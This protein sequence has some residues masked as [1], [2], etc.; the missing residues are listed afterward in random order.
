MSIIA[1][2]YGTYE[3]ER[4]GGATVGS[5]INRLL[6]GDELEAGLRRLYHEGIRHVLLGV[7]EDVGIR[8][9]LGRPGA[10]FAWNAFLTTFLNKQHN[11]FLDL[12]SLGLLGAV[13]VTQVQTTT[14]RPEELRPTVAILDD[15][16]LQ[17]LL[18]IL[19]VE[20]LPIVI[21]GGHNNALPIIR[22]FRKPVGVI[23]IDAH[24]DF[25]PLEG[26]HS[27][28]PFSYAAHESRLSQYA[29][30]GADAQAIGAGVLETLD[31][32]H[33]HAISRQQLRRLEQPGRT[34]LYRQMRAWMRTEHP[35]GLEI[36]LDVI[37]HAPSSASS[38]VG[39]DFDEVIRILHEAVPWHQVAYVHLAEASPP[40]AADGARIVG[41][42]LSELVCEIVS[43]LP[44]RV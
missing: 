15:I 8:S 10:E 39:L 14:G 28:N 18:P 20:L 2:P 5:T 36:D 37:A 41:N 43:L 13:D 30:I 29:L 11:G 12:S 32:M 16:I 40:I 22:S 9:N 38:P 35:I 34:A 42:L 3:R 24:T 21:G 6:A 19:A 4:P 26:R 25:R 1:V 23:N 17:N 44:K 31:T 7:P 27:G 33:W